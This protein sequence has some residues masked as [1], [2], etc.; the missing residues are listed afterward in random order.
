MKYLLHTDLPLIDALIFLAP[1]SSKT[2]LRSWLKEERVFV[3]GAVEK[4][5]SFLVKKDQIVSVGFKNK[6]QNDGIKILYEDSHLVVIEK[7]EGM[8]SVATAFE[9]TK[10]AHASL[11]RK[12]KPKK[13]FV[14][15]RL[16]QDTSGVMLFALSEA[17]YTNLKKTFEQHKIERAYVAVIEGHLPNSKGTWQSHLYEDA[18][19][20]VHETLDQ[21]KGEQAVTHYEVKKTSKKYSLLSLRLETGK[22]NQIRVHCQSSGTPIVGDKKYGALTNPIKRLCLHAYLLAFHHPITGKPMKFESPMPR[23]FS[24]LFK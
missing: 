9:T 5:P 14:I 15:H 19:Y 4:N 11:K 3:D 23:D 18:N 12:Y 6:V 24:N 13:I 8:L 1:D 10:T 21:E 2:T 16:D 20:Y 17:A 7:P 22:K